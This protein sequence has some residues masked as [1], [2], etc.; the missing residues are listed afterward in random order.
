LAVNKITW[1]QVG[2]VADPGRYLFTF[3]WLIVTADDLAI[4]EQFPNAALTLYRTVTA[5]DP[6]HATGEEFRLGMFELRESLS[7]SEK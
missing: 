4:W 6:E 2:R 3:G 5:T 1:A 7:V